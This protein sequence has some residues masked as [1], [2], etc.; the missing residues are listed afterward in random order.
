MRK[1]V[2]RE[3]PLR[4][5]VVLDDLA[6]R[7][8][9]DVVDALERRHDGLFGRRKRGCHGHQAGVASAF[10]CRFVRRLPQQFQTP[11]AAG[12]D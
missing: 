10:R 7:V 2:V 12:G 3:R 6:D 5:D 9:F 4:I 8:G 11:L 1:S